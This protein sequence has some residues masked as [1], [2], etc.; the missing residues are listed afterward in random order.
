M[1]YH[2]QQQQRQSG[3]LK[4]KN[5]LILPASRHKGNK[6]HYLMEE[7]TILVKTQLMMGTQ[8]CTLLV[9]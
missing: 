8:S 4:H 1:T 7:A 5:V 9:S 6:E 2:F 3:M